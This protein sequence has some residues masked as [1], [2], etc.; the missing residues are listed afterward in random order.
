MSRPRAS[1][2]FWTKIFAINFATGVVTG[3]PDGVPVRHE[4][5]ASSRR[6]PAAVIGQPLA[7]EGVYAFFLESVFLGVLL[8]GRGV[9]APRV[10][11][12]CRPFSVWLGSW[13]SGYFIV[14]TDA[15]MQH[16]VG[17]AIARTGASNCAILAAVA[18]LAV[19]AL[20]VR[21]RDVR[22]AP[23]GR[24]HRRGRRRVLPSLAAR[25]RLSGGDFV[26]TGVI[27]GIRLRRSDHLSDRRPQRRR[28]HDVPASQA[29]RHGRACSHRRTDAP[30]A[31][32]GMP[33]VAARKR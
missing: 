28:R 15:W 21:A 32:I 16:P 14:A 19:C 2:R 33:D 9:V 12:C 22:R 31:I 23:G 17:Y 27:V 30:L 24:L 29:R 3:H 7:M 26:R 8:Y 1:P 4:L 25:R 11:R 20:A 13:L 10:V 6:R 18:A 5:G